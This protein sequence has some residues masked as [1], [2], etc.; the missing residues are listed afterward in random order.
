M[1]G[2]LTCSRSI[3]G[4]QMCQH[5]SEES[6]TVGDFYKMNLTLV[7][8][9]TVL[10]KPVKVAIFEVAEQLIGVSAVVFANLSSSQQVEAW[11]RVTMQFPLC[12]V[13]MTTKAGKAIVNHMMVLDGS[14]TP[15][16]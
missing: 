15:P 7:D 3:G 6:G 13:W 10:K 16:L 8:A 2:G 4:A 9:M 5:N 12:R 14:Y 11:R 1:V